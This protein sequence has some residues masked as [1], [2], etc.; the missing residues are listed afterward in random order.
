MRVCVRRFQKCPR[1]CLSCLE[2]I[3]SS[4]KLHTVHSSKKTPQFVKADTYLE[5]YLSSLRGPH[6]KDK[7]SDWHRDGSAHREAY[8]QGT[9][10][11]PVVWKINPSRVRQ[12][13]RYSPIRYGWV[14]ITCAKVQ[15][16]YASHTRTLTGKAK[17]GAGPVRITL[18]I[19]ES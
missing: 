9:L 7:S 18:M 5:I 19:S 6:N 1:P 10:P 14:C 11:Y 13:E 15:Q 17:T 8:P 12:L 16:R 3:P 4:S 2:N